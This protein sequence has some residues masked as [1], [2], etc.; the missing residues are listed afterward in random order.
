M[1]RSRARGG[2]GLGLMTLVLLGACTVQ[3]FDPSFGIDR[4]GTIS[5]PSSPMEPATP[6]DSHSPG[7]GTAVAAGFV[8]TVA[9]TGQAG[10]AD[11]AA[12]QSQFNFPQG[13]DFDS[14]G[15]LYIADRR[16]NRVR[17]LSQDGQ[18]STLAGGPVAG[19]DDGQGILA[20]FDGVADLAVDA[21]GNVYVADQFNG[22]LRK[23][24]PSGVVTTVARGLDQPDGVKADSQ[25]NVY[26]SEWKG[27]RVL[28]VGPQGTVSIVQA[29]GLKEP[30]GIVVESSGTI[31]VGEHGYNR[32]T[33]ISK[34]GSLQVLAAVDGPGGLSLDAAGNLYVAELRRHTVGRLSPQGQFLT[35]A[36]AGRVG[37][38]D[39]P[40]N[41]ALFFEPDGMAV[42]G[43]YLYISD[44]A[45]NA[46]RRLS[47]AGPGT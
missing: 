41:S 14:R 45:N 24:A 16:N 37:L 38:K 1:T 5:S 30:T 21:S 36:G 13:I 32:I 29:E 39:G 23:I 3:I 44:R 47:L 40:A 35:I 22:L 8:E 31:V 43:S 15:N 2:T 19:S 27:N 20:S 26:V 11:G 28:K 12:L 17:R 42:F 33:R 18:V 25:G 7:S 34:D 4:K 46:I 6:S 9:G 10:Y